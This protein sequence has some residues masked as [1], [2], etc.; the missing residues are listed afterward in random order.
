MS[1]QEDLL[2]VT[3]EKAVGDPTISLYRYPIG[4]TPGT[5]DRSMGRCK[6]TDGGDA[7]DVD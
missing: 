1:N 4:E 7:G 2:I 3:T 6:T 5:V